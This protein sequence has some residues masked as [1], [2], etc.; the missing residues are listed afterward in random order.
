VKSHK[1]SL[2]VL[3]AVVATGFLLT[4]TT[5]GLLSVSEE[6]AFEGTI[7]TLDVDLFSDQQCTQ[8]CS[9]ISWGGVYAGESSSEIIYVKNTGDAP[10]TLSMSITNW[11]PETANSSI[12]MTWNKENTTLDPEETVQAT[13][14][15]TISENVNDI[16]NFDY[17]ML[18][19]GIA[20]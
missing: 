13:L 1:V 9:A 3:L 10:I 12:S 5:I 8:N 16:S 2:S 6:V 19:T 14:T 17:K 15:L 18:I 4:T 11:I 7:T 20:Q